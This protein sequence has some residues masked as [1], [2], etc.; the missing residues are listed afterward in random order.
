MNSKNTDN[1]VVNKADKKNLGS[2][3]AEGV[4]WVGGGQVLTQFI[5]MA[6]AVCLARLLLPEDFGLFGMA[7]VVIS[8][9]QLFADF[10]VGAALVQKKI[11]NQEI[12]SSCFWLNVLVGSLAALVLV[13]T[14]PLLA[15]FYG[16]VRVESILTVLSFNLLLAGIFVVPGAILYKGMQFAKIAK[17]RIIGSI[18]G[19]IL[20]VFMAWF[21]F[22]VWSLVAQP[23]AGSTITGILMA[24]YSGWFPQWKFSWRQIRGISKFSFDVF[25]ANLLGYLTRYADKLL[26]GKYLG[27]ESLGYYSMAYQIML[28][29]MNQ[30]SSVIIR[31]LFPTLSKLQEE[32]PRF[33]ELYLKAV[34]TIAFVTFPMM[35]GLFA[36]SDDFILVVFGAK[37]LP[38][39]PVFEVLCF[40]GMLQSVGTTA[41]TI[42]LST[43][44]TREF[45]YLTM[46]LAPV[47]LIAFFIGKNWGILGVAIAYAIVS[48]T[49]FFVRLLVALPIA[50][51]TITEF[52]KVLRA[53]V[54]AS[55]VMVICLRLVLAEILTPFDFYPFLRLTISILVGIVIYVV[56]IFI[57]NRP[58]LEELTRII[59][60]VIRRN[61]RSG[62]VSL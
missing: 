2:A 11:I 17:A 35:T 50:G 7:F 48:T 21:G 51:I 60:N 22:G 8:F 1:L 13:L 54:I 30:I 44:K 5:Q 34:S 9:S 27:S 18:A 52:Q 28:Y 29:P 59:M 31:V 53:T 24:K 55:L 62:V 10:G 56:G 3:T 33:R 47:T 14:S 41:G 19:A 37:W 40:I 16:E 39:L 38:M 20:V 23:I 36:V 61:N 6:T 42:H 57:L 32:M 58:L 4:F 15:E 12:L 25:G 45:L 49:Y 26:V 46:G 43:G